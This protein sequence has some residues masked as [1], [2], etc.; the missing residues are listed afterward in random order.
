MVTGVTNVPTTTNTTPTQSEGSAVSLA[1]N[2]D[3]FL[4][5]LTTQLKNQDPTSP[6]DSKEF[7]TQLVQ[8]SQ[9]EQS[10]NQN[11]N[12]EKL[13][14][15]F[16]SQQ[17]SNLVSYIG[18][19]IDI[20][21]NKSTLTTSQPAFWYYD[22][23]SEATAGE[24][25]VIDKNGKTVHTAQLEKGK[26]EH[27]FVWDGTTAGGSK[28]PA[29]EYKLEVVAQSATGDKMSATIKTRGIVD[30]IERVD[31]VDYLVVNGN[32]YEAKDVMSLRAPTVINN[33]QENGSYVNYIGKEVEFYGAN[34]VVQDDKARWSYGMAANSSTTKIKIYDSNNNL[35]YEANG[36]TT[37]GRHTFEWDGT[38]TDG[39]KAAEGD[40]FKMVVEAKNTD[41]KAVGV[42]VLGRGK[43]DSVAFENMQAMFSIGGLGVPPSW[44]IAVH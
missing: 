4:T 39:T 41:G 1:K 31:G 19:Q 3:T 44:I 5:L 11:K 6:M 38:K 26:G 12:L 15:L 36:D 8:F 20:D 37:K 9:V 40:I 27:T 24:L 30:S 10:I 33:P 13:I 18:K 28:M 22:L 14:S 23:P 7:T 35:V 2:F 34:T 42:D 29:G 17:S 43:I 21:T 32:K 25:R 16:G